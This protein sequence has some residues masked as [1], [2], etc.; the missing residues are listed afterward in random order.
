MPLSQRGLERAG[1][2]TLMLFAP[3]CE[4]GEKLDTVQV[5]HPAAIVRSCPVFGAFMLR[6]G[7]R[8]DLH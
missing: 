1:H 5:G 2:E 4:G 6:W 8:W 3:Y 7:L